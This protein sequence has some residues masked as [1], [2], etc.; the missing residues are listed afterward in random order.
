MAVRKS[1][2]MET[3]KTMTVLKKGKLPSSTTA[4]Q[5]VEGEP[6]MR[7]KRQREK[8]GEGKEEGRG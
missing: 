3:P 2:S 4:Q 7:R 5:A 6:W 8:G 1:R